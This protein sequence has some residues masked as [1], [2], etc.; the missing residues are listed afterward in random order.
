MNS[1]GI[2]QERYRIG[3]VHESVWLRHHRA[4]GAIPD[5]GDHIVMG[6]AVLY[7]PIFELAGKLQ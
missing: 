2:L 6:R 7:M 4:A 3:Y 1:G 5:A